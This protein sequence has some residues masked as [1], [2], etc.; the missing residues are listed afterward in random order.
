M[1]ALHEYGRR[2]VVAEAE[3]DKLRHELASYKGTSFI[4]LG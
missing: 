1:K 2:L 3:A 4:F